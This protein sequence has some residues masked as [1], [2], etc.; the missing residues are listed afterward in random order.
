MMKAD[1]LRCPLYLYPCGGIPFTGKRWKA[2]NK[3]N[4]KYEPC[5][6]FD[7]A[8]LR[9]AEEKTPGERRA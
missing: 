4:K 9:S 3:P 1:A 8:D 2:L 6:R 5:E 7:D